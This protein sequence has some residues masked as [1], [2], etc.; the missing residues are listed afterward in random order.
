M[1]RFKY[2]KRGVKRK[3]QI[4]PK[5]LPKLEAIAKLEGVEK[6]VP[7]V[8]SY[9]PRRRAGGPTLRLTR[10]TKAG[11]KLLAHSGGAI[12]EVFVVVAKEKREEVKNLLRSVGVIVQNRQGLD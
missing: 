7:A 2:I 3:H 1:A 11:F 6:V 12:Q 4:L 10:E 8:I 9:S 5:I